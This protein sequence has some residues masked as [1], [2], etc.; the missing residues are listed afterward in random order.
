VIGG[1]GVETGIEVGAGITVGVGTWAIIFEK[2]IIE[3]Q[4]NG[5]KARKLYTA[6]GSLELNYLQNL[7]SLLCVYRVLLSSRTNKIKNTSSKT[8]TTIQ[9]S[10]AVALSPYFD[11]IFLKPFKFVYKFITAD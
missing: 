3:T 11:E 6:K 9:L 2:K 10:S 4:K 1:V 5:K 8:A 7:W